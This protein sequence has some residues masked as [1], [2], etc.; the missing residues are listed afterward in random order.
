MK[1]H[2]IAV[3]GP[4]RDVE[5][6]EVLPLE[7]ATEPSKGPRIGCLRVGAL[8]SLEE[9]RKL[10]VPVEPLLAEEGRERGGVGRFVKLP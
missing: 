6:G 1:P 8:L 7:P 3:G 2:S 4:R 9:G 10:G 5:I